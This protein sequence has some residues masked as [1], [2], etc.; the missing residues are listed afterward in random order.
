MAGQSGVVSS[1]LI[2]SLDVVSVE[3]V[4]QGTNAAGPGRWPHFI[5]NSAGLLALP[6]ASLR[7][8]L[9]EQAWLA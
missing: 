6:L 7:S 9:N 8:W 2:R 5:P 4:N 3:C 1:F